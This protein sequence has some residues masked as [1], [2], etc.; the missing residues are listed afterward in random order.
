[1]SINNNDQ[2]N[3]TPMAQNGMPIL[4]PRVQAYSPLL[5]QQFQPLGTTIFMALQRLHQ[6]DKY[7]FRL[8]EFAY[9]CYLKKHPEVV[10]D[11]MDSLEANDY[12]IGSNLTIQ[13]ANAIKDKIKYIVIKVNNTQEETRDIIK[14]LTNNPSYQFRDLTVD[15]IQQNFDCDEVGIQELRDYLHEINTYTGSMLSVGVD[16]SGG[17]VLIVHVFSVE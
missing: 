14:R 10:R 2:Q 11:Y 15:I 7:T 1:M 16:G 6:H 8:M 4:D 13:I 5:Q 17:T 3:N 9:W 12:T